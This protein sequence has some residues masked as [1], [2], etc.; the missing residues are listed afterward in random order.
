MIHLS[1]QISMRNA[2]PFRTVSQFARGLRQMARPI[3]APMPALF[4]RMGSTVMSQTYA[5][6][7]RQG[8][9]WAALRP[10]TV[11]KRRKALQFWALGRGR[12]PR[13]GKWYWM[14]R[15]AGYVG[16]SGPVG[17][18]SEQL[19]ESFN[20]A[21]AAR[22]AWRTISSGLRR[23]ELR[24]THPGAH[25]FHRG[26]AT[27]TARPVLRVGGADEIQEWQPVARIWIEHIRQRSIV[28]RTMMT[29]PWI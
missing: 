25:D 26:T 21:I 2:G 20:P 14:H 15:P 1:I 7:V 4:R 27:Q 9:G 18:W 29:G 5:S 11:M 12:I 10:F 3:D 28:A 22:S 16:E 6:F 23:F 24:V 13:T 19:Q 8:P 17:I